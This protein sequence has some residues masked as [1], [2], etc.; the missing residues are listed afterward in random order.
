[1]SWTALMRIILIALILT[2]IGSAA[3]YWKTFSVEAIEGWVNSFD[4]WAPILFIA[5]YSLVTLF[6]IPV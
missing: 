2:G 1:M 3:A 5:A 6:F 4:G